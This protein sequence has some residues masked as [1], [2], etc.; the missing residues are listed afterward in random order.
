MI[1]TIIFDLDGIVIDSE[2]V[3]DIGQAEF[4]RRRSL[5][6]DRERIKHLIT[7]TS[8]IDGIKI[9]QRE[10]GFEGDPE[11]LSIERREI[12]KEMLAREA[13]FMKGFK[14]FYD[15]VKDSYKTCIAT[16]LDKELL[17]VADNKLS[18][19]KIFNGNIF[20]IADVGYASK[21]NPAIFLYAARKMN[22]Q[23]AYCLVIEDAPHG[24]EAAKRAGMKCVA[25]TTTY[26]KEKLT[27]ADLVAD[28]YSQVNLDKF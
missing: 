2:A 23:P 13:K 28:S 3:W 14:G 9:M 18:I 25:L 12:F 11:K 1:D 15:R 6:Y 17:A 26:N 4:L 16:S 22:S 19:S 21:P 7:G 5:V 8:L 24:I 27:G 20:T 10:Y